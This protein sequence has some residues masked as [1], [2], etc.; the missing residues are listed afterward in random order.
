M[1]ERDKVVLLY[2]LLSFVEEIH[3]GEGSPG[4]YAKQQRLRLFEKNTEELL[5]NNP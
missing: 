4:P 1:S 3:K 2:T 5:A